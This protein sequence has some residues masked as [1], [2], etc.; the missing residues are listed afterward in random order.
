LIVDD[1][2]LGPV[3]APVQ[4]PRCK[5]H[6]E[7]LALRSCARCGDYVCPECVVEDGVCRVCE[8][9]L[10]LPWE[11]RESLGFWPGF[12]RTLAMAAVKPQQFSR[13]VGRAQ[14]RLDALL[15]G[16]LCSLA[17]IAMGSVLVGLTVSLITKVQQAQNPAAEPMP[18][19][20]VPALVGFYLVFGMAGY[21]VGSVI[22]AL[23]VRLSCV[24]F[25]LRVST[26]RLWR[27]TMYA[28]APFML[29]WV[30][31]VGLG[32]PIYAGVLS[33]LALSEAS[34]GSLGR[35]VAA[36]LVPAALLFVLVVGGYAAMLMLVMPM[37]NLPRQ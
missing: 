11:E 25:G 1:S 5:V 14:N 18:A 24:I 17:S 21:L 23:V 6:P 26:G 12:F 29:S 31:L 28:S 35:S 7:R 20:L 37:A 8:S 22:W 10:R 32:T 34:K 19:W 15:F 13:A 9:S 36:V 4:A 16:A 33:G 30:P 27:I 2:P 3:V